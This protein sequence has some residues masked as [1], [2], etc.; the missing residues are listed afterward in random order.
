MQVVARRLPP[1]AHLLLPVLRGLMRLSWAGQMTPAALEVPWHQKR[2]DLAVSSG[3]SGLI[4]IE[5]KVSNWRQAID[6]AYVNRW[7]SRWSWVGLWHECVSEETY[8]YASGAGVGLLA[9]TVNTVYPLVRPAPSPRP[10]TAAQLDTVVARSGMRVRDLLSVARGN[11][12]AL[13]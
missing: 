9:V 12:V 2:I 13:A 8:G 7:A 4:T 1:E 11:D 5:L 3:E 10:D 6:Q